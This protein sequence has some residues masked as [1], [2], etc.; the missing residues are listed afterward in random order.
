MFNGVAAAAK[1]PLELGLSVAEPLGVSLGVEPSPP[2]GSL[3]AAVVEPD[4]PV[5]AAPVPL[6]LP[7]VLAL[8]LGCE[9][10]AVEPTV[11][12]L[13]EP[14]AVAVAENLEQAAS[15]A[16]WAAAISAVPHAFV[17]QLKALVPMASWDA[18]AQAWS[19]QPTSL[20]AASRQGT[21]F[22]REK[23]R[24]AFT[25]VHTVI[26]AYYV[27]PSSHLGWEGEKGV[28]AKVIRGGKLTAHLGSPSRSM[29]WA[30][31]TAATARKKVVV[32][33][34]TWERI[35]QTNWTG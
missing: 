17:R 13:A 8:V 3:V 5:V 31:A 29:S 18:Q 35:S 21:W 33:I 12:L 14:V 25:C 34:V 32:F 19:W 10:P 11:D 22:Q 4:V 24:L 7:E 16:D 6:A 23:G 1:L 2:V 26:R 9:E 20:M 15:P 27:S 28:K 30:S